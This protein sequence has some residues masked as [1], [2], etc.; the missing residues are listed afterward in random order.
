[1]KTFFASTLLLAYATAASVEKPWSEGDVLV[2]N[3]NIAAQAESFSFAEQFITD[4]AFLSGINLSAD[5]LIAI[6]AIRM[7]MNAIKKSLDRIDGVVTENEQD[8]E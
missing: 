3:D 4:P 8:Y 7:E 5:V 1:M 2:S 6:E